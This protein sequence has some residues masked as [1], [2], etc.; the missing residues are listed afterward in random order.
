MQQK[1]LKVQAVSDEI[2][3]SKQLLELELGILLNKEKNHKSTTNVLVRGR[4]T[5]IV[6]I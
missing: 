1:C 6:V 2:A 3:E 4:V 5:A